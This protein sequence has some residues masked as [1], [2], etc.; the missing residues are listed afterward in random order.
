[1]GLAQS[2][3]RHRL[4]HA[5]QHLGCRNPRL[6]RFRL[7]DLGKAGCAG[8]T[9]E[10]VVDGDAVRAEF[11][12]EGFGPIGH[13]PPNGVRYAQSV[14]RLLDGR[15]DDIDNAPFARGA[16]AR[17]Q[18][19]NDALVAHQ[20]LAEGGEV[21]RGVCGVGRPARGSTGVVDQNR[22]GRQRSRF[23]SGSRH[24]IPVRE[25]R[26]QKAVAFPGKRGHGTLEALRIAGQ[27]DAGR[28]ERGQLLGGGE[29]DALRR[30][31]D[32][33]VLS[34]EFQ[35]HGRNVPPYL[36]PMLTG[37]QH[38]HGTLRW[39]VLVLLLLSI[40]KAFSGMSA[41]RTFTDGD[42]KRGLFTMIALHLQL[43]L[44]FILYFG[45]G[46]SA[47]LGDPNAMASTVMRFFSLEH[48]ATMT[49]AILLGTLGYSLSKRA[50]E[51]RSKFRRQAIWFT[52]AL[53][54]ILSSIPWP[55]REGFEAY[56][57]L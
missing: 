24:G 10:D 7:R 1:M 42:R 16:H 25:V 6:G 44:G 9:G 56:G 21:G 54:L 20:V 46:W 41:G 43:V 52:V 19:L 4:G 8:R 18:G 35:L 34:M 32:Q 11:V 26:H 28:T 17:Q 2:L 33:G 27:Q 37:I 29:A 31:T 40:V 55:F 39:V 12:G 57:W 50:T 48:M 22:D 49:L 51:D 38:L 23:G 3:Q 47:M 30:P 15:G 5:G 45:K 53:L 13:R 36:R 14:E